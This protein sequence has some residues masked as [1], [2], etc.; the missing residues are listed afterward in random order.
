[1]TDFK[2]AVGHRIRVARTD[3]RMKQE[4]LAKASG[5]S[6]TGIVNI[7]ILTRIDD[8]VAKIDARLDDTAAKPAQRWDALVT[9]VIG[10]VVA[11]LVGM[12]MMQ[13]GISS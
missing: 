9:Q 12:A 8:T 1:M 7:A 2:K 6:P 5:V 4:D 3:A 13:A 11:A 10:L